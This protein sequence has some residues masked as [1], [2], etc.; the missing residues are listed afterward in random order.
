MTAPLPVPVAESPAVDQLFY[1]WKYAK[2][3]NKNVDAVSVTGNTFA[4][5]NTAC[6]QRHHLLSLIISLVAQA[7]EG[8]GVGLKRSLTSHPEIVPS[9]IS[10]C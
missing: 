3:S 1:K 5:G 8:R 9:F 10:P 2:L 7:V 4:T 6:K